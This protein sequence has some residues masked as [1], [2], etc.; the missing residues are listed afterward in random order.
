MRHVYSVIL[1]FTTL[2][3]LYGCASDEYVNKSDVAVSFTAAISNRTETRATV[4]TTKNTNSGTNLVVSAGEKV[5]RINESVSAMTR[6][7]TIDG[8]WSAGNIAVEEGGTVKEYSVDSSGNITSSSPFYWTS[9]SNVS[10]T[11][12]YPYS[13]SLSTWIVNSNQSTEAKYA[14]SDL[15][16]SSGT[17]TYGSSNSLT[18]SH[19]TAKVVVNI[20][21]ANDISSA[22]NISFVTIGT[23]GTPINLSGTVGTDGSLTASTTSTGY[24]T[25]YQTTSSTYAATYSAL[26]IPQDMNGKQFIAIKVAGGNIFYYMPSTSTSLSGGYVYTYN[27]TVPSTTT[28]VGDYYFSDGSWGTLAVHANSTV[29]PIGVIFSNS[30]STNDK[31]RGWT[32]GYALALTNASTNVTTKTCI[33]GPETEEGS[34]TFTDTYGTYTY[35]DYGN[36]YYTDF[37]NDKDGYCET[38]VIKNNHTLSSSSYPALYYAL[39]YGTSVESGTT[40]YA[41]PSGSSG[42]YLPSIGQWYDIYENL[43]GITSVP[44]NSYI[45][46][47]TW[48]DSSLSGTSTYSYTCANNINAYLTAISTYSS[49]K[50]Y[51]YGTPD[52][53]SNNNMSYI[54]SSNNTSSYVYEP[55]WSSSEPNSTNTG[56]ANYVTNGHLYLSYGTKDSYYLRVRGSVAF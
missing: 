41:A 7:S 21:K 3:I 26:V 1:L 29:Y 42:W 32:H 50:G 10:V 53:F 45:G 25:P 2:V 9:E 46:Y 22:S 12:W 56:V 35:S 48:Y 18:Y 16:Y 15:L 34:K 55:Y 11:S 36:E 38:Q 4:D 13:A 30:P 28:S 6:T 43:G 52:L 5:N 37:T 23:S 31:T 51:S 54:D 40:S 33:W 17:L 49:N 24:I 19:K 20:A 44:T 27:V 8:S 47:C 39:S 14:A